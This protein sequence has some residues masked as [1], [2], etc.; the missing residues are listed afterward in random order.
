MEQQWIPAVAGLSLVNTRGKPWQDRWAAGCHP[1]GGWV[2]VA[3][4]ISADPYGAY[5]AESAI[6]V[7]ARMLTGGDLLEQSVLSAADAACA[8]VEPWYAERDG[9]TTLTIAA[10][11]A[12]RLSVVS[13]GDSP[14]FRVADRRLVRVTPSPRSGPL[15][16][17]VGMTPRTRPWIDS[18]PYSPADDGPVIVASD[19]LDLDDIQLPELGIA[20]LP[21]R[22][23]STRR[24]GRG[25]DASIAVLALLPVATVADEAS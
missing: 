22:L 14:A 19:G 4:G 21:A 5:A 17:W 18:W 6:A 13:V 23:I 12:H 3:D 15:I 1:S 10:M 9:G 11:T 20:E 25:D 8:A 16:Q 7:A 24:A 2:M